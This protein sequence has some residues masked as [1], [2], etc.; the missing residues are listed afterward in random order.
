[1]THELALAACL[2][3]TA[4]PVLADDITVF[5][6]AS[7]I[8][9][10]DGVAAAWTQETGNT[11]VVTYAGSSALARQIQQGAPADIFISASV[12]WMDAVD[13][14]GD[15]RQ[16]TR[17]DLLT[18]TLVL[19]AHGD[20]Q[21][22]AID[23]T[24][25][26]TAMLDGGRLSMAMVDSVPA[27][28]YGKAALTHLGLWDTVAPMVAQSDNVRSAL[29]FVAR[30]EAPLGIVYATDA[31]AQNDVTIVGRFPADSHDPILYPAAIT[32]QSDNDQA[33]A[34]LD[35]LSSDAARAIWT[36]FGFAMPE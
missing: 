10:L 4:A 8:D 26:L 18:N 20:A 15:M 21:P 6:A 17:R 24:L 16:G 9:A 14:S 7:L 31:A 2:A 5:A 35:Y 27:G 36:R 30:G 25:D 32:A 19:I 13:S 11:A 3:M 23:A 22:V 1:M 29:T 33:Q 12:D 34:F 28:I